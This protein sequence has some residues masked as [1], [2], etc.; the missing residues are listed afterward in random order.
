MTVPESSSSSPQPTSETQGAPSWGH[1]A[2]RLFIGPFPDKLSAVMHEMVQVTE[3]DNES[4]DA[5]YASAVR[6]AL[7]RNAH[8]FFLRQ[9]GRAEDW[10][11]DA[12]ESV[13]DELMKRW[14]EC[15]WTRSL[16]RKAPRMAGVAHWV[17]T[18]FEVGSILGVNVL[19]SHAPTPLASSVVPEAPQQESQVPYAST[20]AISSVGPRSYWTARSHVSPPSPQSPQGSFSSLPEQHGGE[21]SAFS[22]GSPLLATASA[23]SFPTEHVPQQGT[24]APRS[25]LKHP[26][27]TSSSKP[28]TKHRGV[29]LL[30]GAKRKVPLRPKENRPSLSGADARRLPLE[31]EQANEGPVSPAAVLARTGNEVIECSAGATAEA[32]QGSGDIFLRD[33]ML[34]RVCYTKSESLSSHFDEV[35]NR[36]TTHL[37]HED[38]MEFLVVWRKDM[39][40]LYEDYVCPYTLFQ[41]Q[42]HVNHIEQTI[43]GKEYI[44]GHKHLAFLIPLASERTSVSLYSF[45]DLTFCILCPPTP[46]HERYSR[47][48]VFFNLSKEGTNVFVFKVKSRSRARDWLWH[49]WRHLGGKIPPCIEIRCPDVDIRIRIDV[50][51]PEDSNFDKVY[52]TF[53]HKNIIDLIQRSLSSE[54][55]SSRSVSRSWKT[56]IEH[57]LRA[58][59]KLEL[60]WRFGG[61]LDWVW[62][63]R[64]VEGNARPWA[65][66]SGLSLWQGLRPA[67]LELRIAEHS[68]DCARLHTD[69]KMLEPPAIEGYLD[70]IRQ[71]GRQRVYLVTHDGNLFSL[72]P[73]D[74]NPPIPPSAHLSRLM[75]GLKPGVEEYSQSLFESEV[76]RGAEQIRTALGTLDL[77]GIRTV[78]RAYVPLSQDDGEHVAHDA[79]DAR[80][81]GGH[82]G[83][84]HVHDRAQ[85]HLRRAFDI[86]LAS[87]SVI[88]FEAHS[89]HDCIEWVTRLRALVTY[90]SQRHR[91]DVRDE[92]DVAFAASTRARPTPR[93]VKCNHGLGQ[94]TPPE[95]PMNSESH[96][97]TSLYNWC[98]LSACRSIVKAGR[99]FTRKG[100]R[101][102]YK[103]VQLFLVP[104]RLIKFDVSPTSVLHHRNSKEIG[105]LDA[106]VCSGYHAALALRPGEYNPESPNL[107][108]RYHD[109]L[110][111]DEREEDELFV[112]WYRKSSGSASAG[113][114][115]G[116][117]NAPA[118]G[119]QPAAPVPRLSKGGHKLVVFRAR[120]KIERDA[121]CWALGCE[122]EKVVRNNRDRERRVREAG[123]LVEL[124]D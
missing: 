66:L 14:Q 26:T 121:W 100:L 113:S 29:S 67:H 49:L 91:V 36:Q 25:I 119:F 30:D 54:P 110:E 38:C 5:S 19:D 86:V 1:R 44:T 15:P 59:K 22:S 101:G 3:N 93:M 94:P 114:W 45:V 99:V 20:T 90:W 104:G 27:G 63:E 50:P 51:M 13:R 69:K 43:P 11:E 108:R 24:D 98:P 75:S 37:R 124:S 85:L 53:G 48:R 32:T 42:F 81:T 105:L 76:W 107:P 82:R 47:A 2:R 16:R 92:M 72:L 71:Q 52:D 68:L 7:D 6:D 40:E 78:R 122:I 55:G 58:G 39:L 95:P 73:A 115:G 117:L 83:Q 41:F 103:L 34:V 77:R 102:Q 88:R 60:A 74:A 65:V 4:F 123:G 106:Y 64:D 109:G 12:R 31:D 28:R 96:V 17:G 111:T 9:G 8:A 118:G 46:V 79:V 18:T 97:L 84:A 23:P 62:Q 33:R 120:N 56:I 80:D 89:V 87:G 61:Q 57:E 70:R 116:R 35:Q 112:I 21:L 10:D